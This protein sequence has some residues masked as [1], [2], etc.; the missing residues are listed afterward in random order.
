MTL[1]QSL[2][3]IV[4][5]VPGAMRQAIESRAFSAEFTFARGLLSFWGSSEKFHAT[6]LLA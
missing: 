6:P 1:L 2:R 4:A 5:D 3:I